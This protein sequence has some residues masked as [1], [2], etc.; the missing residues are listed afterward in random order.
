MLDVII[1]PL[2][3]LASNFTTVMKLLLEDVREYY[4]LKFCG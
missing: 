3:L 2:Q 4:T 1:S